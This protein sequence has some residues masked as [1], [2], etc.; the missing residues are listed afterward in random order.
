MRGSASPSIYNRF[1]EERGLGLRYGVCELP[2]RDLVPRFLEE[3]RAGLRGFN[4]TIPYKETVLGLLDEAD[5]VAM[6]IGAVNTVKAGEGRLWGTN[7]DWLGFV[8]PLLEMAGA[9]ER[10]RSVIV[11]AGGAARAAAYALVERGLSCDIH[12]YGRSPDRLRGFKEHAE[13]RGW[14]R[15]VKTH[16][17]E[18]GVLRDRG[19]LEG[20]GLLVNATPLGSYAYPGRMPVEPSLLHSG[21]FVFDMV[22]NPVV[23]PLVR[24]AMEAGAVVVDG[25]CMLVWQARENIRIWTGLEAEVHALRRYALDFLEGAQG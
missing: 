9:P 13:T 5:T 15:C 19:S 14:G 7:T 23:T 4:V 21:L 17:V 6:D 20:A 8:E 10:E 16:L 11:G 12:V 18:E 22:Y 3:A 25:L 2:D 1:F 24:A